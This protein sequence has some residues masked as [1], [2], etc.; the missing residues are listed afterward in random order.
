MEHQVCTVSHAV[1]QFVRGCGLLLSH[2][3]ILVSLNLWRRG[4][5]GLS[6]EYANLLVKCVDE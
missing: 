3:E 1:G 6:V 5:H 4:Q 2:Q